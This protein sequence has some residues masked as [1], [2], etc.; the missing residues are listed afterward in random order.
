MPEPRK[1]SSKSMRKIRVIC[2]DPYATD[3]SSS[4]DEG[5]SRKASKKCK[6]IVREIQVPLFP[7]PTKT[8][9]SESSVQDSNY[10]VGGKTLNP[11]RRVL[12]KTT[13]GTKKPSSSPYRGVRQRKWG[14]WAAEIRDPFKGARLW[15]GTYNTPEEAS[16]AYEAKRLEFEAMAATTAPTVKF[17]SSSSSASVSASASASAVVSASSED[18]ESVVS[19]NSPSSVLELETSVSDSKPDACTDTTGKNPNIS[20]DETPDLGFMDEVLASFPPFEQDMS[21]GPELD[22]LFLDDIDDLLNGFN[23]IDDIQIFGVDD[24]D[25]SNLPD[26]DFDD[27][28]KDDISFWME[29]A[30]NIPC[31]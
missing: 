12:A 16:K 3:S 29:G 13:S 25:S 1:Q 19:H 7:K 11:K 10:G 21:F 6:R 22:T 20:E 8:L 27:L 9:E 28:G 15:L 18:S 30:L 17:N 23:N 2:S 31:L 5:F 26:C 4:E 14:K 24:K